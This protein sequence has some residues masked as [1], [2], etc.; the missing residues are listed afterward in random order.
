MAF[1]NA[2]PNIREIPSQLR[3]DPDERFHQYAGHIVITLGQVFAVG[4]AMASLMLMVGFGTTLAND[5]LGISVNVPVLGDTLVAPGIAL[6]GSMVASLIVLQVLP[7]VDTKEHVR[8]DANATLLFTAVA[9]IAAAFNANIT[10]PNSV[11]FA[12]VL[13]GGVMLVSFVIGV[14]APRG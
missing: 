14:I 5:F 1:M 9:Y 3:W 12:F 7:I 8:D 11:S 10:L 6:A 4:L 13:L 2:L